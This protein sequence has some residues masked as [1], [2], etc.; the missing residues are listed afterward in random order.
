LSL[1]LDTSVLIALERG[2]PF[3]LERL[4]ILSSH[5][6]SPPQISFMVYFEFLFGLQN[7]NLKNK[8]KALSLLHRF[9][10]LH[11][12]NTTANILASL[13]HDS[14]SNGHGLS[15][16]D[17]LIGSQVIEHQGI[18]L[19]RNRDFAKISTLQTILL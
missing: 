9:Q 11:T 10:V 15:L 16:A 5:Y 1:I 17:L 13:K 8:T 19:T 14:D 12:T 3:I 4:R 2:D 7:K 18:L 6:P